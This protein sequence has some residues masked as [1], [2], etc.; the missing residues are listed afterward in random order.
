MS[1][2]FKMSIT[3]IVVYVLF[4]VNYRLII[5]MPHLLHITRFNAPTKNISWPLRQVARETLQVLPE[6]PPRSLAG[7]SHRAETGSRVKELLI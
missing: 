2:T 7:P 1:A 3:P 4:I 6:L 5:D